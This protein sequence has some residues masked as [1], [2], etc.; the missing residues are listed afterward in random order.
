MGDGISDGLADIAAPELLATQEAATLNH[1]ADVIGDWAQR[2]G[3]RKDWSD[4]NYLRKLGD[5]IAAGDSLNG[6]VHEHLHRIADAHERLTNM[7]KL[8]LM[9]SEL[10]E[11]LEGAR[12]GDDGNYGEEL[13]D[14]M[15]RILENAH[16]NHIPIGDVLVRKVLANEDRPY[17]HG[18]KF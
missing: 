18:K 5:A 10:T 1:L 16:A 17:L 4:A 6:D 9:V 13:A 14:A 7:T 15:I 3:F 11:A 8:M 12:R 2:K